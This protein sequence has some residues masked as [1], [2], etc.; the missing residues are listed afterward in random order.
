MSLTPG[1]NQHNSKET[2][3]KK[4]I[5]DHLKSDDI[6]YPKLNKFISSFYIDIII[7]L[8]TIYTLFFD[9]IRII[10]FRSSAD[11]YFDVITLIIFSIFAIDI[12]L[13]SIAKP[14][15]FISFFFWLDIIATAT[16]ILDV[17]FIA[18]AMG[19]NTITISN[20]TGSNSSKRAN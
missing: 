9:D 15:Y 17:V 1:T 19:I 13:N 6:P 3:K 18:N 5:F 16:L 8:C 7:T 12:I 2:I 14:T 20:G 4:T 11:I 10:G